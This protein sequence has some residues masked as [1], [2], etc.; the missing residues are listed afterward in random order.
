[1]SSAGSLAVGGYTIETVQMA[2]RHP[3]FVFGFIAQQRVERLAPPPSSE[4]E[5]FLVLT[6]GVGMVS[7]GDK[8]GQQYRTPRQVV[9]ESGCDVII[10][11]RGI[12]GGKDAEEW[13]REANRYRAEGWKAYEDRLL[14]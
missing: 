13:K 14:V 7:K 9:F 4:E 10:V 11:G 6:P 3:E 12:Y 1:M 2:R 8:M 5:D